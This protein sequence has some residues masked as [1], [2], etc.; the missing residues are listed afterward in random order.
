MLFP[1]LLTISCRH[2]AGSDV[3]QA[4]APPSD[5]AAWYE[6]DAPESTC[7]GVDEPRPATVTAHPRLE[8]SH[9]NC[10]LRCDQSRPR[11]EVDIQRAGF[12]GN[13]VCATDGGPTLRLAIDRDDISDGVRARW[14]EA[15]PEREI[16]T[17]GTALQIALNP[18]PR[19]EDR[20]APGN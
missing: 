15:T 19:C 18:G 8:S 10:M 6:I 7:R 14:L 20:P 2:H 11:W 13:V 9:A 5:C 12:H 4:P 16:A 3:V 17:S 1:L